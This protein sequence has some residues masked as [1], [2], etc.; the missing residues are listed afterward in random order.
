MIA[1]RKAQEA[2]ALDAFQPWRG[3][4]RRRVET[5]PASA[6]RRGAA[7]LGSNHAANATGHRSDSVECFPDAGIHPCAGADSCDSSAGD[8]VLQSAERPSALQ[9]RG[10]N[11][12]HG[13]DSGN[14]HRALHAAPDRLDTQLRTAPW[15]RVPCD[16]AGSARRGYEAGMPQPSVP[17]LVQLV[18]AEQGLR[19]ALRLSHSSVQAGQDFCEALMRAQTTLA[20]QQP[21][22]C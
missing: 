22:E 1:A 6:S 11:I 17:A 20:G 12:N 18:L 15:Q 19:S 3:Y 9:R 10:I 5:Q 16:V 2:Y 14:N 13:D 21:P 8:D 4:R 7:E